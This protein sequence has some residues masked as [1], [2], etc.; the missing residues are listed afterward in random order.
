MT[1]TTQDLLARLA[2]FTPG[3]WDLGKRYDSVIS[4]NIT[5]FD[6]ART[7]DAYGGHLV[8]E[9]AKMKEN[10][11][12]IAAA[13]DLHRTASPQNRRQRLRGFSTP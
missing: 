8:C 9:S 12:L 13:P 4:S 7:V 6:D 11:A 10:A 1:E 5:G 2:G 3:P